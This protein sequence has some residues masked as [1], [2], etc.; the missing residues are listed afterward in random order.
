ME[1]VINALEE[2]KEEIQSICEE[3]RE[4]YEN[5]PE[6]L[7]ETERGSAMYENVDD[8]ESAESDLDDIISNLQGILER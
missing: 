1:D 4:A 6:Q 5:M 3:E 7:Q 8:L 2:Q